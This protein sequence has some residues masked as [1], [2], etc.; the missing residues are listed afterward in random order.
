MTDTIRYL[1]IANYRSID[2]LEL[3]DI[4]PFSVFAGSNGA[5]KSN[6]F[7]ALD[8][9]SWVIRFG[10]DE[11]LKKHGGFEQVRCLRRRDEEADIFE[12]EIKIDFSKDGT[13]LNHYQLKIHQLADAPKLAEKYQWVDEVGKMHTS[14]QEVGQSSILLEA[15][16]TP[17]SQFLNNIR[18]YKIDPLQA[19]APVKNMD[20]SAL[21]PNGRN[22]AGVL[23]RLEKDDYIY[24][25]IL[26]WL[27][28]FVPN[29]ESVY[30]DFDDKGYLN[31]VFQEKN[32]AKPFPTAM[33]SDGMISMLGVLVALFD[34]PVPFG[35]TLIESP[36]IYLHPKANIELV[37]DFHEETT[38]ERPIWVTT[39][40]EALVR[41]L[42]NH[43]LWL[44][45]K[46]QGI[47]KMKHVQVVD[48]LASPLDQAW[49]C[50]VLGGGLP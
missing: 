8:F 45:D 50:N 46:K 48:K 37:V 40:N 21:N 15:N 28:L 18:L 29:F 19:R 10:A 33:V 43:E 47:T 38:F 20:T 4:K 27:E 9:V 44:V 35:M 13:A 23:H 5:G 14:H 26:E 7:E 42:K 24:P 31:L 39:H 49:L 17:L 3:H 2:V 32:L 1:K 16:D 41:C 25:A 34:R 30:T 6:F 11:A 36:E 22:L 12:F